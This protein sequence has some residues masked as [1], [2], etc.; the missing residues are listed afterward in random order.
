MYHT[1]EGLGLSLEAKSSSM[2][3]GGV[4]KRK[5]LHENVSGDVVVGVCQ[6]LFCLLLSF[7]V[8]R[9]ADPL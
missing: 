7:S 2:A 1:S 8:K 9:K 4:A 3:T 5:G 6:N